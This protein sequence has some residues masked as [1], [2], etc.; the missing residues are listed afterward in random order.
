VAEAAA[1]YQAVRAQFESA[2]D[3]VRDTYVE[4][5]GCLF[6]DEAGPCT[7]ADLGEGRGYWAAKAALLE[8]YV[9]GVRAIRFPD[10]AAP[11]AAAHVAEL[12]PVQRAER[13]AANAKT[14]EDFNRLSASAVA[15]RQG[16]FDDHPWQELLGVL[17]LP[18]GP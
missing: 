2:E 11:L 15:A 17:R 14:S 16:T 3:D 6:H 7:R 1:A 9:T 5:V 12:V 4:K 10:V 8:S 13:A 18:V